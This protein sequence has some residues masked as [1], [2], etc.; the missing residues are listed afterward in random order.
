EDIFGNEIKT[1]NEELVYYNTAEAELKS[2]IINEFLAK[3]QP[4]FVELYNRSDHNIDLSGWTISNKRSSA[5]IGEKVGANVSAASNKAFD[6]IIP[7]GENLILRP[8]EYLL[9]TAAPSLAGR[10]DN[11]VYISNL[12]ALNNSEDAIYIQN[13]NGTVIDSI[14]YNANF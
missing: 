14:Y 7:I 10:L 9:V 3:G 11:G 1:I 2:I 13:T 8:G 4:E 5:E 12:P 6:R